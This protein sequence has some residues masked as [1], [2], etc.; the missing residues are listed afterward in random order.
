MYYIIRLTN[1]GGDFM[2][3]KDYIKA[4]LKLLSEKV[5]TTQ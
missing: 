4:W 2:A 3:E 1:I 5:K